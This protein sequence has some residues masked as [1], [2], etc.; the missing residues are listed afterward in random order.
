MALT[1]KKRDVMFAMIVIPMLD[2]FRILSHGVT[3]VSAILASK[4][5]E[6]SVV[7]KV[8]SSCTPALCLKIV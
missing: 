8:G 5:M 1:V 7:K 6:K 4:G 2:V 3:N